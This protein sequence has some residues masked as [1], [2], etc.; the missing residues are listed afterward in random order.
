VNELLAVKERELHSFN[1]GKIYDDS[2]RGQ[3]VLNLISKFSQSYGEM[4]EGKF[5]RESAVDCLGGSR[6]NY[7]FHNIFVKSVN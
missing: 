7:I 1:E 4:I 2:Q 3:I 5:V 6:I